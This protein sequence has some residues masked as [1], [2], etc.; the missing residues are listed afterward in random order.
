MKMVS[1]QVS[2]LMTPMPDPVFVVGYPRSGTTLLY[3][4]LMSGEDFPE[5][6]FD[7]TH[8]FSHYYN[9][10][11]NLKRT[12]NYE[13]FVDE[14]FGRQ[15]WIPQSGLDREE[16]L[17]ILGSTP[18]EYGSIFRAIMGRIAARQS[19]SRWLEK[20][21]WHL[22]WI[23]EI[24]ATFPNAKIIHIVRD[25]RDVALSVVKLGWLE[26]KKTFDPQVHA[27]IAWK[28]SI[29]RAE[30]DIA[31]VPNVVLTLRYEDLVTDTESAI[32]RINR[33]L[34][35][36]LDL[37]QIREVGSKTPHWAKN[38]SYQEPLIGISDTPV[39]R[40]RSRLDPIRR[41]QIEYAVGDYLRKFR[42]ETDPSLRVGLVNRAVLRSYERL[43]RIVLDCRLASRRAHR[44]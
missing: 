6:E 1:Q 26:G 14:L 12:T 27:A 35:T 7:E 25:A 5:C 20:T 2:P 16:I 10:F 31:K 4:I 18:K 37:A 33:F 42:Y 41:A 29:R 32:Q 40:W 13:R 9:R 43:Y 15:D 3:R 22:F 38:T 39:Q 23:P 44:F 8:F 24:L 19:K 34:G 11:G 17:E 36:E 21:P 28:C 30:A